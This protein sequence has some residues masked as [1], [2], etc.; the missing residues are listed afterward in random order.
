MNASKD[1]I[2]AINAILVKTGQMANKAEIVANATS[3]RTTHSSEL[4]MEEANALLSALQATVKNN[5]LK[6]PSQKMTNKLF[7]MAHEMGWITTKKIVWQDK[8][9]TQNDYS[10]LHAW[11]FKYGFKKCPLKGYGYHELPKLVSIF[12]NG[13]YKSY[14]ANINK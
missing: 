4:T 1:K 10:R 14:I 9:I 3:N 5:V 6:H 11:I 12:E 8:I 2:K 7:A 13:P